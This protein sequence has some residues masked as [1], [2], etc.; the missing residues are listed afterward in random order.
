MSRDTTL[1]RFRSSF[2][3]RADALPAGTRGGGGGG[4]MNT[5]P[6]R[7]R[8]ALRSHNGIARDQQTA[9]SASF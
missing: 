3:L 9:F 8:M 6:R 4:I 7:R 5:P 2:A 1:T